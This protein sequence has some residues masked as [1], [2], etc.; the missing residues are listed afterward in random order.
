MCLT[1]TNAD[2]LSWKHSR[3]G[4]KVSNLSSYLQI[5]IISHTLYSYAYIPTVHWF[6][7]YVACAELVCETLKVVSVKNDENSPKLK[8]K[9]TK[10]S[11]YF[12]THLINP[13]KAVQ[14][15]VTMQCR[16]RKTVTLAASVIQPTISHMLSNM[17]VHSSR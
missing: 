7:G 13:L 9:L 10:F 2:S 6:L 3:H 14:L 15:A 17:Q 12:L 16:Y 1:H 4:L 11:T 8:H 5:S